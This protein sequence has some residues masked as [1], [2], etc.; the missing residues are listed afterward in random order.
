MYEDHL[1]STHCTSNCTALVNAA[2]EDCAELRIRGTDVIVTY[3]EIL[4]LATTFCKAEG[5]PQL[6]TAT[7]SVKPAVG[8]VLAAAAL[9]LQFFMC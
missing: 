7:G 9:L 8:A 1:G 5:S 6:S 4:G 3:R 2:L